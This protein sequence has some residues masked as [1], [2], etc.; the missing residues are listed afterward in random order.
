MQILPDHNKL[1]YSGR[2]DFSNPSAPV[3]VYP[4]SYVRMKFT[5]NKIGI[6][7]KNKNAYWDNYIGYIID[8]KQYKRLLP[9]DGETEWE[10]ALTEEQGAEH[11]ILLFKR[12]DSCHVITFLGF[13]IP[14]DGRVLELPAKPDRRIEVYGDSV[15]AGEVSE[16]VEYTG[17]EDPEHQGQ[18]SNSWYS[19]TW[20]TARNLN[21]QL[22]DIA[23]GG[24]AL[25]PKTGWFMEPDYIGMEEV[26][27][28]ISY[29]PLLGEVKSWDFS[30]YRPQVVIVALGQNDSHPVDFMKE[31]PNGTQAT[32]WKDHYEAFI[33]K[34][35]EIYP[36][37]VIILATTILQHS[38]KW[39]EAIEEV[40]RRIHDDKIYH[41]TYRRNGAGTPGHIRIGEAEEMAEELTGFINSL[42]EEIW[43]QV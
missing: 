27:D 14:K 23:Q 37:A 5:G 36:K 35:R 39:D 22:H 9:P 40:F 29:H 21:A 42:G 25:M 1:E 17:K 28:K 26:Y 30:L 6:R 4:C 12:M 41:F 11:E 33:R 7:L 8:G 19:Y 38:V 16:A 3:M 31:E 34:L 43:N 32:V 18:Y 2:I 20:M 13:T 15:S 10:L 24:I